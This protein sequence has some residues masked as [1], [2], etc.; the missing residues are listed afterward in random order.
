M[1]TLFSLFLLLNVLFFSQTTNAQNVT[2]KWYAKT[3]VDSSEVHYIFDIR[4]DES[5]YTGR[6]DLPSDKIFLRSLDTVNLSNENKLSFSAQEFNLSFE[7][8]LRNKNKEFKGVF[9]R[10]KLTDSITLYRY[11]QAKRSQLIKE[12]LPYL[13]QDIYFYNK[14]STRLA[15]TVTVPREGDNFKAVV[16]VSGSGPQNRDEEIL[17][18]KPFQV[19]AD[20][21]TRKGVVVLRY[22][23]RGYGAS[24]GQF[25]PAT[26]ENYTD[27]ALAAVQFLKNNEAFSI[28]KIGLIGHSEGGNIVPMA[29]AQDTDIDFLVLLA[30]P[31]PSNFESYLVS[32]DLILKDYPETYERDFAF[33][34]SVYEDM[35]FIDDKATLRDSLQ[36]KFTHMADLMSAD[37]LPYGGKETYIKGQVDYHSSDWYHYYLQFDVSQYLRQLKIPILALNGDKDDSV[38]ADYNLAGIEN[39]LK[40]SEHSNYEIVKLENVNHFFQV[41]TDSK[42]E[43]VYFNEVT[44]SEEALERIGEW[45]K[46]L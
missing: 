22:D 31:A 7:G 25:R 17:G 24:R 11:P 6:M 23:D 33:F 10:N 12:P 19:L 8:T 16:L 32:L 3:I 2:G 41:S 34:K 27:D 28:K 44:F 15:G 13:S 37:E 14:D 4:K 45:I 9:T 40:E 43:N 26:S 20:Y 38:E 18:H 36:A 42:I 5:G 39:T 30:A 29:A 21:L 35:K 46:G 1:K